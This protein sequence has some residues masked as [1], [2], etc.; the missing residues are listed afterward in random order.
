MLI[1]YITIRS[2][3]LFNFVLLLN[4][5]SYSQIGINTT[6]PSNDAILDIFSTEKGMLIPRID[7]PNLSNISPI[8]GGATESLL[9]YN[10]NNTTGN[11]PA[12][13]RATGEIVTT[14]EVVDTT[15]DG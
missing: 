10:T 5:L 14:T 1:N 7:I 13:D 15:D 12:T 6:T 4:A 2:F 3:V 8:T 11:D 9:A